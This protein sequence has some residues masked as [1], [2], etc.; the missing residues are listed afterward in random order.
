MSRPRNRPSSVAVVGAALAWMLGCGVPERG[1][2][3]AR[4]GPP[5]TAVPTVFT[6]ETFTFPIPEGYVVVSQDPPP[7]PARRVVA[8]QGAHVVKGFRPT[9]TFQ[10]APV[11]GGT[12]G[13][14][15]MCAQTGE[16]IA[17]GVSGRVTTA[18]LTEGPGGKVCQIRLV[19]PEGVALITELLGPTETWLM[20]CNHADGDTVAESVCRS[21]LS[22]FRFTTGR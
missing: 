11:D 15:V 7:P 18:S 22:A 10:R 5:P 8:L 21:T 2:Q 17:R 9:I 16:S 1:T 13:D 20:T 19:A 12:M 4:S 14:E 6:G 3:P